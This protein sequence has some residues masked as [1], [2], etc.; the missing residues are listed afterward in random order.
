M[1]RDVSEGGQ[2]KPILSWEIRDIE[3]DLPQHTSRGICSSPGS[4]SPTRPSKSRQTF[5]AR[6]H[7]AWAR[8]EASIRFDSC[9]SSVRNLHLEKASY[10]SSFPAGSRLQ[11]C[12]QDLLPISL[13]QYPTLQVPYNRGRGERMGNPNAAGDEAALIVSGSSDSR[14]R[15]NSLSAVVPSAS[16]P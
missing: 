12:R 15:G 6:H 9:C 3:L 16:G 13:P 2:R 1:H 14:G 10:F 5:R 7:D 8:I 4:P 11:A